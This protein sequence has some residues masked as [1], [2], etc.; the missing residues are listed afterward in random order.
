MSLTAKERKDIPKKEFGLPSQHKYP[1]DTRG[2]AIAAEAYAKKEE[3]AGRLSPSS[4]EHIVA[5]AKR[6]LGEHK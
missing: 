6:F 3:E 2:R 5:K 4:E 1:I